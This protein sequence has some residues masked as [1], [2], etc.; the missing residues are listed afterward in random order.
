MVALVADI[1]G[2]NARF[3]LVEPERIQPS[4]NE[5]PLSPV[6]EQS[7]VSFAVADFETFEAA[8]K[9]YLQQCEAP[10]MSSGFGILLACLR[11][12]LSMIFPRWLWQYRS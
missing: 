9:A 1:G 6:I 10:Q 7:V 11:L 8:L 2:T 12:N 5:T 4:S 3:A